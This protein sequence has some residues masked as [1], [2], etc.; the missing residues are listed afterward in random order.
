MYV[1][2][3]GDTY[4]IQ[5]QVDADDRPKEL[6]VFYDTAGFFDFGPLELKKS[7][8]QVNNFFLVFKVFLINLNFC[9]LLI[10]SLY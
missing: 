7:Y 3:I 10:K 1:P 2:T 5:T 8:I 9:K 6:I 4:Q